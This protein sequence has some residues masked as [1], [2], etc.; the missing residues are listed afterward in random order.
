MK[1][2]ISILLSLLTLLPLMAACGESKE[3]ADPV[4]SPAV[5]E[6]VQPG[7]EEAEPEAEETAFPSPEIPED[8]D[9]G[10][11]DFTVIYPN[12]SLYEHYLSAEELNGILKERFTFDNF[13]W[14][15]ENRVKINEP[16]RADGLNRVLYKCPSCLAEGKTVGRGTLLRC[17][18]CGKEWE[19]DEF[20]YLVSRDGDPVFTHVPDWYR[21]ERDCVKRELEEGTYLLDV[22]V[23][24]CVMT[25][26]KHIARVGEGRLRH[27]ADGFFL[28][29]C[30]GALSCRQPPLASYGL[31]ADY[32]WYE[33]G[34]MICIGDN[35]ILYYCFPKT[36]TDV[37]AKTRIAAEEL[38]KIKRAEKRKPG[39]TPA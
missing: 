37:V 14:Q 5:T 7:A 32:F 25:N 38:Y 33:L 26:M 10:G 20:G 28:T 36:D 13:R 11:A 3:N 29:G 19:L 16:F 30:G 22:P 8:A 12:W 27:D 1:R 23:S 39:V 35:R 34:D 6:E 31:Y 17:E 4:S 21:W 9:F 18:S 24:I 15:Q 2:T